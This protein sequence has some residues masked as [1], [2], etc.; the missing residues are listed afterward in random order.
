LGRSAPLDLVHY[1]VVSGDTYRITAEVEYDG[2]RH[3]I[4]GE[5]NGPIAALVHAL[6]S[7]GVDARVLDYH[8]HATS[9]GEEAQAAS[10]L[11]VAVGDRV[12]WGCGIHPS[13]TTASLR[14]LVSAINRGRG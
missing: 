11:E 5:G 1:S 13:I 4:H 3:T 2:E 8:E 14:A 12:L 9:A 6:A 10:Y 7:I